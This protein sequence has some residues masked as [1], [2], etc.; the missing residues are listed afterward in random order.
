MP[1]S[2]P[3]SQLNAGRRVPGLTDPTFDPLGEYKLSYVTLKKV[4]GPALTATQ[5]GSV[6]AV[7]VSHDQ[8]AD[9]SIAPARLAPCRRR[10]G[11]RI[12]AAAEYDHQQAGRGYGANNRNSGAA[13]P[14]R[15]PGAILLFAGSARTRG[16]F[17]LTMDAND[18]IETAHVFPDTLIVPIHRDGWAHFAQNAKD[19]E[20]SFKALGIASRLLILGP[21]VPTPITA[22]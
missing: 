1:A 6:D 15:H 8:H 21:V 16:P 4:V 11:R 22:S 17:N 9:N 19:L 13:W 14:G 18:A 3:A 7:L 2:A 5:V 12:G 20:D 10:A